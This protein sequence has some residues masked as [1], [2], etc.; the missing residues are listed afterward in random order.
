MRVL[1]ATDG[2]DPARIGCELARDVAAR[3]GGLVRFV[4]VLPPTQELFGGPWP[5]S[6]ALDP[7]IVER[8]AVQQLESALRAEIDLTPSEVQPTSMLRR[9]SPAREIVAAARDW[10]ADLIV[11]GSRG[12]NA[13]ATMLLG[14]VAEEVIDRSPVPVLVARLPRL[15][16]MVVGVD[17]SPASDAA[18]E[19]VTAHLPGQDLEAT[20]VDVAPPPYPWWLGLGAA[21]ARSYQLVLDASDA[22]RQTEAIAADDAA[23]RFAEARF[24]T[25]HDH[26]AGDAADEIVQAAD[27]LGADTIVI[28]S[29]GR[30]GV[31]RM[32]VGSVARQVL[33]HA[34]QSVLVVH[35]A[36]PVAAAQPAADETATEVD[37]VRP[38][39][40]EAAMRILLA[41]DGGAPARRALES[42]ASIAK[43]MGASL[44]VIS[45]IPFDGG[46]A[47]IAPWDDQVVH[48]GELLD[49]KT[50][51]EALGIQCRMFEPMGDPAHEIERL[52]ADGHYH[53]VVLGSRHLGVAGRMLQGSVSEHVATHGDA[54]VV[55]VR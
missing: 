51:L 50:R 35:P 55:V 17:G 39:Q 32:I 19:F 15:R 42:A 5:A 52:A 9:G 18:I 26:R 29:R 25:G 21:D 30:T 40:K 53:M 22:V 49:A 44:D 12:H 33:R 3:S 38:E 37:R 4:A 27:E 36:R 31:V 6:A 23:R 7:E 43:A 54:T 2:S 8:E 14:S 10:T 41:Y 1:V 48:D 24:S 11:V 28:G 47:P 13:L 34:P 45:V 46:R 16:R 20:V